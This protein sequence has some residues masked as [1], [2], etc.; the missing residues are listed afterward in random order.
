MK[1]EVRILTTVLTL[2]VL[3]W[4]APGYAVPLLAAPTSQFEL[5]TVMT[6][7]DKAVLVEGRKTVKFG[8]DKDNSLRVNYGEGPGG[9]TR[10]AGIDIDFRGPSIDAYTA[11]FNPDWGL[12]DT[13]WL[14]K[15]GYY[16]HIEGEASFGFVESVWSV[17][18]RGN[19]RY[20]VW[21]MAPGSVSG[22]APSSESV[23]LNMLVQFHSDAHP[24]EFTDYFSA[25]TGPFIGRQG[26]FHAVVA[27]LNEDG[28]F[29]KVDLDALGV[30]KGENYG[31]LERYGLEYTGG[32]DVAPAAFVNIDPVVGIAGI[33]EPSPVTL[34]PLGLV[35]L[36]AFL[37]GR[38]APQRRLKR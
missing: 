20:A 1:P 32:L 28:V 3:G 29:F 18:A 14:A 10:D 12:G 19:E 22:F 6:D 34:F 2:S 8:D 31:F 11:S 38:G 15:T 30:A 16:T 26:G 23:Q 4:S 7:K 13:R 25:G 35:F 33:P 37:P 27:S 17:Q 36:T 9:E 24:I 5:R 21:A